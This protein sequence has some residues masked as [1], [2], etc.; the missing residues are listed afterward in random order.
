MTDSTLGAPPAGYVMAISLLEV[1]L[2]WIE[3]AAR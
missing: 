2:V 3:V 1:C